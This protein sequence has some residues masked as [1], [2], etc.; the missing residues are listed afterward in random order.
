MDRQARAEVII[1]F[2]RVLVPTIVGK[3]ERHGVDGND[4]E[5]H[6]AAG[7]EP[8]F[9][10]DLVEDIASVYPECLNPEGV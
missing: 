1:G 4:G 6:F 5:R 9:L 7:S 8:G 10:R 3:P 2:Q